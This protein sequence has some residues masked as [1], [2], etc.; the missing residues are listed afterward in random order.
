MRTLPVICG[1]GLLI[2][3][4]ALTEETPAQVLFNRV[5]GKILDNIA[6]VPRYTCVET[7][8]RTTHHLQ[9]G[10]RLG[11]CSAMIA[12]LDQ[13]PPPSLLIWRDRLR[14]DVAVGKD[15]EMFSWA[16]AST[17]ETDAMGDLAGT[18]AIGSGAFSSFLASIFGRD[19]DKFRYVGDRNTKF[20]ALSTFEYEV[21]QA[22][23]HYN[24]NLG[25]NA[26][27]IIGYHGSF[28][29]V[30]AT[31]TI[32]RLEVTADHFP[33]G[34]ACRVVDVMD[35]TTVKIGSGDFI[36]PEVSTM[37]VLYN[38]GEEAHNET[39]FSGCREYVGES[40]IIFDDPSDANSPAAEARAALKSLPP[41]TRIRVKIDPPINSETAAAGDLITGVVE[42]EVKEKGQV[43]V[44]TSDRLHG[45]ILQLEQDMLP[46]P[47]WTVAIR[48]ESI[49]RDGVTQP[50]SFKPLDDGDRTGGP[51]GR[52]GAP[53]P[54]AIKRPP[55]AGVFI[56]SGAGN[57]TLDQK[58]HSEWETR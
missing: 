31:A 50:V 35:Y 40:K 13:T 15:S 1:L 57:I 24:Y 54:P 20:G 18:G 36:L 17:F 5:R 26:S 34:Q 43:V 4:V 30:P 29:V 6:K 49:E 53:P 21:P 16:G 55:G 38:N 51:I 10:G 8:T 11:N 3:T 19:A 47:K 42:H 41:K 33:P 22:K 23:S 27:Q 28:Y 56:L 52:R 44:R 14:I 32:R 45:R 58:F 37:D 48:F 7:I 12:D 2:A 25:R 46:T 9:F 39:R